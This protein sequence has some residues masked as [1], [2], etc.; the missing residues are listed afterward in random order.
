MAVYLTG[1]TH[2]RF[3][4]IRSFCRRMEL[5]EDDVVVVLGDAGLN[6]FLDERD[7]R[8]KRRLAML[9][10][11]FLFIH[12]N[13]EERPF[14]VPG[15]HEAA[16]FGGA[17]FVEDDYPN[18]LF[19][20]DGEVYDLDGTR[21]IAIGGAYSVDKDYRLMCGWHWFA[22]EQPDNEIKAR[23]EATLDAVGWDVDVV[24]SHTVPLR[25][26]PVEAFMSGVDQS[27]VDKSTEEW[28]GR[29][30]ARLSYRRWYAGH[31]HIQKQ[32]DRLRIMFEDWDLLWPN[33]GT[34]FEQQAG[35]R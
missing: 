20:K 9:P 11:K 3:K 21:C 4:R 32:I 17:V 2:G 18:I 22:S 27:K 24:L 19:A 16:A 5:T 7:N 35:Q 31:Y 23:V 29:I 10:N 14:N 26:E 6:Y 12:G 8:A 1:D 25:Y 30:E 34:D 15:Y 33:E 28:L 13:H